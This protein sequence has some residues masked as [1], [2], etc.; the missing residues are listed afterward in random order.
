MVVY[1]NVLVQGKGSDGH[2][3]LVDAHNELL[4]RVGIYFGVGKVQNPN[5]HIL[6]EVLNQSLIVLNVAAFQGQMGL[7]LG[8]LNLVECGLNFRHYG[9]VV[10]LFLHECLDYLEVVECSKGGI[11]YVMERDVEL[12]AGPDVDQGDGV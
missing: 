7:V 8:A 9:Q 4:K 11:L 5:L 2:V 1:L 3:S 12:Q 6:G 10:G